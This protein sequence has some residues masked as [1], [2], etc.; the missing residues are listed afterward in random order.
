MPFVSPHLNK[1]LRGKKRGSVTPGVTPLVSVVQLTRCCQLPYVYYKLHNNCPFYPKPQLLEA[2]A[3]VG[4]P[5]FR[6]KP[7]LGFQRGRSKQLDPRD[8][9][10][11]SK[12]RKQ[13]ANQIQVHVSIFGSFSNSQFLRRFFFFLG[14]TCDLGTLWVGNAA[15]SIGIRG[16]RLGMNLAQHL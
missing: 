2:R 16:V 15:P 14:L 1:S 8:P 6:I 9:S 13:K 12:L 7:D 4:T 11:P 3:E 10:A 5:A